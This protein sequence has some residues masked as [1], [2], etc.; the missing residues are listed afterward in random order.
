MTTSGASGQSATQAIT[1]DAD[2]DTVRVYFSAP[3]GNTAYV[4]GSTGT[5]TSLESTGQISALGVG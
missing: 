2:G 3:A 1:T 4:L 5:G